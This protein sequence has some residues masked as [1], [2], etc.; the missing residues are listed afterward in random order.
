MTFLRK[1]LILVHRYLGIAIGLLIVMWFVSGIGMMYA[2]EMPELTPHMRLERLAPLDFSQIMLSPTD[3][4][5]E[6]KLTQYPERISS[7]ARRPR[8]A[9]IG[10]STVFADSGYAGRRLDPGD[11]VRSP[12]AS[13]ACPPPSCT[14]GVLAKADQWTIGERR[15]MPLHKIVVDDADRTQLY[16]GERAKEVILLTTRGTRALAWVSAIPHWLYFTPLRLQDRI[17]RRIMVWGAALGVVLAL[18]GIGLAIFQFS[19]SRP[20]RFSRVLSYNPYSG[21]MRWHYPPAWSG[22]FR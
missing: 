1:W 21:L 11:A 17:W 22:V 14:A 2:K 12:A 4:A 18:L 20:F 10:A 9:R 19:P 7:D 13:C 16:V 5:I 6:A 15:Q 8:R 3:A